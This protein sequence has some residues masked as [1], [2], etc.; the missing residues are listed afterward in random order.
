MMEDDQRR[1]V[2]V[3]NKTIGLGPAMNAA[4]H[5]ALGFG[6][7][8][9]LA[10]RLELNLLDYMDGSGGIHPHISALSLVVLQARPAQLQKL[11]D[12]AMA[13]GL[14]CVSFTDTMTKG[15]YLDQLERTRRTL[16]DQ[17][18]YYAVLVLGTRLQLDPLTRRFSLFGVQ[19]DPAAML[20]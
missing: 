9:E 17:L 7:S 16:P 5:A 19:K 1:V 4:A 8:R 18:V 6:A 20:S 3:V 10:D 15:T 12:C 14:P 13:E 2:L 11:R